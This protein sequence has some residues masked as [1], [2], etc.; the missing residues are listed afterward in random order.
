MQSIQRSLLTVCLMFVA[1]VARAAGS[2]EEVLRAYITTMQA[3]GVPAA[4]ARYTHPE[5]SARYK[6]LFMPRIRKGFEARDDFSKDLLGETMTLEQIEAMAPA[7]FLAKVMRRTRLDGSDI[8]LPSVLSSSKQ[9]DIVSLETVPD[10]TNMDGAA[11][12]RRDTVRFKAYGDTWRLMLSRE[13]DT[14]A[15]VLIAK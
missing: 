1:T 7:E 12:Q 9:G 14:Y 10:Y 13:M 4:L 15:I 5:E 3:E 8:K 2:P 6:G 11:A